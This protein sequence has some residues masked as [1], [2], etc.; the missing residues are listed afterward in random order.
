MDIGGSLVVHFIRAGRMEGQECRR[1]FESLHLAIQ[2]SD[3][4]DGEEQDQPHDQ[5][6]PGN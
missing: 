4:L 6:D 3:L 2:P 5:I 1:L